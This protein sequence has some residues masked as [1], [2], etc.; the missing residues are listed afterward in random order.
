MDVD[1]LKC[2]NPIPTHQK[3]HQVWSQLCL[4]S[5]SAKKWDISRS[6]LQNGQVMQVRGLVNIQFKRTGSHGRVEIVGLPIN[7]MVDLSSSL[8]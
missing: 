5:S 6:D 1:P 2:G 7:S 4:V 3:N 8:C